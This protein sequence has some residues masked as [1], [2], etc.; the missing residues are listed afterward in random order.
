MI[1]RIVI[2]Q[3]SMQEGSATEALARYAAA[4]LEKGGAQVSTVDLRELQLPFFDEKS[5]RSVAQYRAVAPLI[6]DADGYV[7][8]TPDYHGNPS[9]TL[10]NFLDYFWREF[11]GKLFGYICLSHDKGTTAMDALRIVVRQCYGWSLP[12]GVSAIAR[13]DLEP[14]GALRSDALRQR[15]EMMASDMMRY[16]SLLASERR[17]GLLENHPTFMAALRPQP[18]PTA[19]PQ[20]TGRT[21]LALE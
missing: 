16:A 10:K 2:V 9:G 8:G 5:A 12:Y 13:E 3:G 19:Q 21:A 18:Q 20:P 4:L 7:L 11:T 6:Q 17:R 14:N 15:L 1:P